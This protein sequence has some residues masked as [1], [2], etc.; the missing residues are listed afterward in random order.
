MRLSTDPSRDPERAVELLALAIAG[1]VELV[2]TADA[3]C[4][5]HDDIGH[6]ERLIAAACERA[7]VRV[8]EHEARSPDAAFSARGAAPITIVTKGG[9]V[10]P[11]GAWVANGRGRH[12]AAAARASRDRLGVIDLYL[13]HAIDPKVP[14]A[15]S[16]RALAKLR[17]EGIVRALGLSNI[18]LSQLEQ[19]LAITEIAAVEVE[20]NPWKLDA[21]RG[22]VLA[23]CHERG[24]RVLAHRPLGGPAGVKRA[25][26]HAIIATIAKRHAATPA[27][28]VLAWLRSLSPV[29]VTLPGATRPE[30]VASAIRGQRLALDDGARAT[31]HAHFLE[32]RGPSGKYVPGARREPG[33]RHASREVVMIAGMPAAGKSTLAADHVARGYTRLNRDDRGG[34]LLDLA[35][36]I[37]DEL[38]AGRDRIVVDNTYGTRASRAP[39]I[40]VARRHGAAVRC[41]VVTTPL[42]QAQ[43]HA[44]ARILERHGRLD[45]P[46]EIRPGVQFRYRREFEAPRADEGFVEIVEVAPARLATGTRAALIVELDAIVWTGKPLIPAKV[47]LVPGA[48]E[49]L[50][51]WPFA[52]ATLWRPGAPPDAIAALTERLHEL[53]G[54][55]LDVRACTHLAGP[56][57]CWCR[58]PLPGLALALARDHD[59]DLARS[60]HLG[61]N[62]ADRGFALRAGMAFASIEAGWPRP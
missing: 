62:P 3:Y 58:K 44:C 18:G 8:G 46:G 47:A 4:H 10:R 24:I 42:E 27:E 9:L 17:D 20:L 52:A 21:I 28:V 51:A 40:E 34:S 29:I 39:V 57:V 19:A 61:R 60:V 2:D 41:I 49:A 15:T 43:A 38:A 14:F 59:L 50:A 55:A 25:T 32:V 7:A 45:A 13:L 22:G 11:G 37:D 26:R 23:A 12:L 33:E 35:R 53:L 6:N 30:T 31:L 1:G 54:R 16:V 5:D 56:P 36:A 48:A